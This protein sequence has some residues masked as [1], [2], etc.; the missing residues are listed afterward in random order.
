MHD[1]AKHIALKYH[2]IRDLVE[3]N[4]VTMHYCPSNANP[5][6]LLT[7]VLPRDTT[8]RLCRMI[9]LDFAGATG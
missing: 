8:S 6:D 5:A 1:K 3:N 7:K 2:Y 4:T 9:G